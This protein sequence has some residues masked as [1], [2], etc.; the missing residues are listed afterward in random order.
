MTE[1]QVFKKMFD[2]PPPR[3]GIPRP[4]E[5]PR[6]K[7]A[8]LPSTQEDIMKRLEKYKGIL[9]T[10][11]ADDAK[12]IK[13]KVIPQDPRV[14]LKCYAPKCPHYGQSATCP[15][16]T[17]GNFQEA[18]EIVGAYTWALV[19]RVNIPK[20]GRKYVTGPEL[21]GMATS[22]EGFHIMGSMQ[23]YVFGI[24]EKVQQA[25]YYDGLYWAVNCHYGPCI[26]ML[27][28]EFDYC[29][30]IKTG[31]CRFPTLSKPSFEQ[32]LCIDLIK[33]TTSLGWDHYMMGFCAYPDDYPKDHKPYLTGLV[34]VD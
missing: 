25:A 6:V 31:Q 24:G 3:H 14:I 27:C 9:L 18:R 16:H 32:T 22:K 2:N 34:L 19:Y 7:T 23:R 8:K 15:P 5:I 20:K 28:E 29:Q 4:D 17:R 21:L 13:A 10:G 11:G 12:I 26:S 30:E 33:L 1:E